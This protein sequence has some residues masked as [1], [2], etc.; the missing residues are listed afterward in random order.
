MQMGREKT[1]PIFFFSPSKCLCEIE[2]SDLYYAHPFRP[3]HQC[4]YRAAGKSSVLGSGL[5]VK[6]LHRILLEIKFLPGMKAEPAS[7]NKRNLICL[8]TMQPDQTPF[9]RYP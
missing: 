5:P 9:L 8:Q 1:R 2:F 7:I 6:P 3:A 4:S